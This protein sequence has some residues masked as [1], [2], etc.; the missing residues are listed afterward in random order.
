MKYEVIPI[1]G[2][3]E[4][5]G[6]TW[7]ELDIAGPTFLRHYLLQRLILLLHG[8]VNIEAIEDRELRKYIASR[9]FI[10]TND[11]KLWLKLRFLENVF[12]TKQVQ[13]VI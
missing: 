3:R 6:V 12:I 10:E 7:R 4:G 11:D 9:S 5:V 8:P 1:Q 13:G 2:G